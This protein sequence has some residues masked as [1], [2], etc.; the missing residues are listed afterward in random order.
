MTS[1]TNIFCVLLRSQFLVLTQHGLHHY[2]FIS[3]GPH[4]YTAI[5]PFALPFLH[6]GAAAEWSIIPLHLM[7]HFGLDRGQLDL[8]GGGNLALHFSRP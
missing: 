6:S 4:R 2:N 5:Q 7:Y 1:K 8:Q 3:F